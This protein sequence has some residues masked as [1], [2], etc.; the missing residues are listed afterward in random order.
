[1]RLSKK[2]FPYIV[3]MAMVGFGC[4]TA[5]DAA[6]EATSSTPGTES[7]TATADSLEDLKLSD[8]L[9]LDLPD[10]LGGSGGSGLLLQSGARSSEA[11][12]VGQLL[13]EGISSLSEISGMFCHF[14][15]GSGSDNFRN[16]VRY[17]S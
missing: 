11:C 13:R 7:G 10:A 15:S 12:E 17:H 6:E 3:A 8:A 9:A 1:M 2:T 5:E 16:E 4:G 14:G